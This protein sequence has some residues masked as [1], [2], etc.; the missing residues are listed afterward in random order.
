MTANAWNNVL[1]LAI[2][3]SGWG[4]MIWG[5]SRGWFDRR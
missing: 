2:A 4:V 3:G 1:W 5:V